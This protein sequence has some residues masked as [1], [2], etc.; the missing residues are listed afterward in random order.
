MTDD[1]NRPRR[2]YKYVFT[3]YYYIKIIQMHNMV[4]YK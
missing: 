1:F 3:N 4:D 2:V